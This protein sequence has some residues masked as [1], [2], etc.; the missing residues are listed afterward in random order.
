MLILSENLKIFVGIPQPLK[1]CFIVQNLKKKPLGRYV[2]I[3]SENFS[4]LASARS[5]RA[6]P[7]ILTAG[8]P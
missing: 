8:A 1:R 6:L 2:L 4:H 3:L 5:A 7:A